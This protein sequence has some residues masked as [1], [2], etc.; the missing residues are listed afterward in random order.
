MKL[1]IFIFIFI[2]SFST[3]GNYNNYLKTEFKFSHYLTKPREDYQYQNYAFARTE[4]NH[5]SKINSFVFKLTALNEFSVDSSRQFYINV[6][7]IYIAYKYNF[8]KLTFLKYVKTSLGREIKAWNYTDEYFELGI[9]NSLNLWEPLYPTVNGLVGSFTDIVS[10]YWSFQLFVGGIFIPHFS[11]NIDREEDRIFSTSRWFSGAPRA[12]EAF[13]EIL[14]ID[15]WVHTPFITDVIFQESYIASLN[16]WTEKEKNMWMKFN[17]GYKPTNQVV[18]ARN[19]DSSLIVNT[20][21]LEKIKI[22]QELFIFPVRHRIFS[23]EW[24]LNHKGV[25]VLLSAGDNKII[26]KTVPQGWD[27]VNRSA[28]FLYI[29]TFVK[30]EFHIKDRLKNE[31]QFSFINLWPHKN[32]NRRPPIS[33]HKVTQGF[34]LDWKTRIFSYQNEIAELTVRYWYSVPEE[35]G[36]LLADLTYN[37]FPFL[38]L[39][40]VVNVLGVEEESSPSFL[41]RFKANDRMEVKVGYVF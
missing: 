30:Y 29:S 12:V 8:Q 41:N 25:S 1:S 32:S 7:E 20:D 24:G 21:E 38:Y 15:Y 35:G 4:L 14:N 37:I 18:L 13:G 5:A 9:W 27:L 3:F 26:E 34:G 40:G 36:L 11:V 28:G 6:P 17:I 19:N 33:D 16:L 23:F 10:N 2:F 39:K 31:F 22:H